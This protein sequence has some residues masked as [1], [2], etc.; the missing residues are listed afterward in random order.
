MDIHG[1]FWLYMF[2]YLSGLIQSGIPF[3]TNH[4]KGTTEFDHKKIN[5]KWLGVFEHDD[6]I[7]RCLNQLRWGY[8]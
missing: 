1:L 7:Q 3:L 2:Q 8:I 4:D 6:R 5:Q